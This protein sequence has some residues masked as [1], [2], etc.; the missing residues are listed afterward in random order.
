MDISIFQVLG[1]IAFFVGITVI[2]HGVKDINN[3]HNL[4]YIPLGIGIVGLSFPIS[5]NSVLNLF[6]EAQL[7][8][9]ITTLCYIIGIIALVAAIFLY[10]RNQRQ[11]SLSYKLTKE[12]EKHL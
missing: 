4:H 8:F 1:V 7:P 12:K 2:S 3:K 10:R 11:D 5:L 6:S 9:V